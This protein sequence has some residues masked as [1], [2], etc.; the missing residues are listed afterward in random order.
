ML[1][2]DLTN[3]HLHHPFDGIGDCRRSRPDRGRFQHRHALMIRSRKQTANPRAMVCPSARI[4]WHR[5]DE[6]RPFV[7]G[8]TR[9]HEMSRAK[10]GQCPT[11]KTLMNTIT[12]QNAAETSPTVIIRQDGRLPCSR[13]THT[14]TEARRT[15]MTPPAMI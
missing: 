5:A 12:A 9:V 1:H 14:P 6:L 13:S 7:T 4:N 11:K 3:E 8:A 15:T 10:R 2:I